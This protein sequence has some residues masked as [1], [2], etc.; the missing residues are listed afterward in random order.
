M[1]GVIEGGWEYVVAAYTI[2]WSA[3]ILYGAALLMR[4]RGQ[5]QGQGS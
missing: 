5:G 4:R 1:T 2:T 3:W